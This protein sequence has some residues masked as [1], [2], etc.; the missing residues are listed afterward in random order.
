LFCF[1]KGE[2]KKKKDESISGNGSKVNQNQSDGQ[3]KKD[4]QIKIQKKTAGQAGAKERERK[5]IT[6]CC[7]GGPRHQQFQ[8]PQP[9]G[10]ATTTR[11]GEHSR[12]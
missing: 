1:L 10:T 7:V 9:E 12:Y 3:S 8:H 11:G 4:G 2:R 6:A 5:A